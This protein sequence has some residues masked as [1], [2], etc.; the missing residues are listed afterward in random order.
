MDDVFQ[1]IGADTAENS[2]SMRDSTILGDANA[3]SFLMKQSYDLSKKNTARFHL[4]NDLSVIWIDGDKISSDVC[5]S[6]TAQLDSLKLIISASLAPAEESMLPSSSCKLTVPVLKSMLQKC[7]RR[8]RPKSAVKLSAALM[9]KSN[10]D[11]LRRVPVIV[12]EDSFLHPDYAF[13]VWLM[14]ACSSGKEPYIPPPSLVQHAYGIIYQIA[15]CPWRDELHRSTEGATESFMQV[16]PADDKNL[17]FSKTLIN[18][19]L[20][21]AKYGGM[22]GDVSMLYAYAGVWKERLGLRVGSSLVQSDF[23]P[24]LMEEMSENKPH[25]NQMLHVIHAKARAQWEQSQP[26]IAPEILTK[27]DI[28]LEGLDFHCSQVLPHVVLRNHEVYKK[29]LQ[30]VEGHNVTERFPPGDLMG[31]ARQKIQQDRILNLCCQAMWH[32]SAGV[33]LRRSIFASTAVSTKPSLQMQSAWQILKEP[34]KQYAKTY[35]MQR[36]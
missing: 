3:L 7:V 34:V 25:W 23:N 20:I 33:N 24:V 9:Y 29:L 2:K 36:F 10:L 13:L 18:S 11:L 27:D 22:A 1:S 35:V 8:R 21:R 4:Q 32:C 5:W 17:V 28:C 31:M 6:A 30:V 14:T 16:S 12:L 15:A 19:M 26:T